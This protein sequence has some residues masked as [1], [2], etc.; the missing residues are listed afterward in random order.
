MSVPVIA[1]SGL[2]IGA[3]EL[4][5]SSSSF[6]ITHPDAE[7]TIYVSRTQ[8]SSRDSI[9]IVTAWHRTLARQ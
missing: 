3:P 9:T 5:G 2:A 8:S 7:G 1:R 4:H 6:D